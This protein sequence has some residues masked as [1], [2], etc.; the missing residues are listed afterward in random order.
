MV[1]NKLAAECLG[2]FWL[3]LG[4]CGTAVLAASGVGTLGVAFAF[5]L[6]LITIAFA[7]APISGC[8]IN[9]AVT[10][11]LASGGRFCWKEVPGYVIAQVVGAV[12]A[13]WVLSK[14]AGGKEG[15]DLIASGLGANGFGE[16]SPAGY[17]Q[18]AALLTEIILT[19]VFVF[20]IMAVTAKDHML[21]PVAIGMTLLLI[22][23]ISIPVT[24]TSV[25]PARSTGPALLVGGWALQQLW[26]F[27]VAPIVGGIIGALFYNKLHCC[28][29]A[30]ACSKK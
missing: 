13:A 15:F 11:G 19:A 28:D 23:L 9:P 8:H 10:I 14:I 26:L 7:I 3:V 17:S 20:V 4:G 29:S 21:A 1:C 16:H 2:T 5:G 30:S 25:N 22:H 12:L 27:W 24:N 6:S 18:D